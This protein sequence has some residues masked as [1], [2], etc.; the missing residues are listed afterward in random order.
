MRAGRGPQASVLAGTRAPPHRWPPS[1]TP[2]VSSAPQLRASAACPRHGPPLAAVLL[3]RLVRYIRYIRYI[4]FIRYI[5]LPWQYCCADS[6]ASCNRTEGR[7]LSANAV[8]GRWAP[9]LTLQ[10]SLPRSLPLSLPLS[11]LPRISL[12]GPAWPQPGLKRPRSARG[13]RGVSHAEGAGRAGGAE[14]LAT[15]GGPPPR[16]HPRAREAATFW[17]RQQ[18]ARWRAGRQ[19]GVVDAR[20]DTERLR[21]AMRLRQPGRYQNISSFSENFGGSDYFNI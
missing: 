7:C 18:R 11:H 21:Q 5:R 17:G 16:G 15:A 2:R 10:R 1:C 9:P 19:G 3:R 20:R 4:R 14:A 8:R 12:T 6:C 13:S